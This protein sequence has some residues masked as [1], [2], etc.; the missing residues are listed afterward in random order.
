MT[1]TTH[2]ELRATIGEHLSVMDQQL[3]VNLKYF[4][5]KNDR[6]TLEILQGHLKDRMAAIRA[7]LDTPPAPQETAG[8]A[9]GIVWSTCAT[10]SLFKHTTEGEIPKGTKL[11]LH[12]TP[13]AA[14][15]DNAA[16]VE[17]AWLDLCEKDDRT[18]PEDYPDMCLITR[19]ELADYIAVALASR[20][21][22]ATSRE[23]VEALE[24]AAKLVEKSLADFVAECGIYDPSTGVTEFSEDGE[25]RV[26]ELEELAKAIR[27]LAPKASDAGAK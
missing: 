13:A 12:P 8:E 22:E 20:P 18:S 6:E 17:A 14:T 4:D 1:D 16:L 9:V 23:R 7:L 26:Y 19:E 25:D 11:Y 27:A 3:A 10:D 5:N 24:A 21:A 15:T 2:T